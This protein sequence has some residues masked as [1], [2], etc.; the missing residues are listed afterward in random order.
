MKYI[1]FIVIV[2]G[3]VIIAIGYTTNNFAFTQFS[4]DAQEIDYSDEAVV[5]HL[6]KVCCKMIV[7]PD[8]VTYKWEELADRCKNPTEPSGVYTLQIVDH[9]E[10][11]EYFFSDADYFT[12]NFD[13]DCA[14]CSNTECSNAAYT[15]E[16]DCRGSRCGYVLKEC[17]CING[18]CTAIQQS[19][20]EAY[21]C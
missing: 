2:L 11:I 17:K 15:E 3:L 21:K 8:S 4:Q 12:C 1:F 20:S 5:Y 14:P 13:S 18:F 9:S 7:A 10:C 16:A 19:I 6:N